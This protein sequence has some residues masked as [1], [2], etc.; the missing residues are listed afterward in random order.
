MPKTGWTFGNYTVPVDDWGK[1]LTADDIRYTYLWGIDLVAT[2]G[3]WYTDQQIEHH[4][5]SATREIERALDLSIH[6][7]VLKCQPEDGDVF[8]EEEDPYPYRHD[9]WAKTGRLVLRRRPVLSVERF[10]IY[11][12]TD[13]LILDLKSWLRIDHRKGVLNWFPR[14]GPSGDIKASPSFFALGLNWNVGDYPHG[15]KVDYTA[16]MKDASAVPEDLRDIIGKAAAVKALNIVGDGFIAGFS[17]SS[18]SLDG[19]SES[20][21]STQSATNAM[22]GARIQVYLKD[23]ENYIKVN[24]RKFGSWPIGSI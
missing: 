7:R 21:S 14:V 1:V 3:D 24:R 6:K 2:N 22:Y 20:F 18:L 17:S 5:A 13:Q 9:K 15:Y 4:V 12:I 19:V 10:E 16:G 23:I 11:T 8:D